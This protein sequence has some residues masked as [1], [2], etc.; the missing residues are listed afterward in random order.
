M[1]LILQDV[2]MQSSIFEPAS[3]MMDD[4]SK[5]TMSRV[6][7]DHRLADVPVADNDMSPPIV[8]TFSIDDSI[9]GNCFSNIEHKYRVDGTLLGEGHHGELFGVL[10]LLVYPQPMQYVGYIYAH[11]LCTLSSLFSHHNRFC[12]SLRQSYYRSEICRQVNIE[13]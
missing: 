8:G 1:N 10:S 2:D 12:K 5:S 6:V 7:S 4:S 9:S 13:E 11:I 3:P